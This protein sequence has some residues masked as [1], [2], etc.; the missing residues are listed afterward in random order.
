MKKTNLNDNNLILCEKSVLTFLF[1]SLFFISQAQ[2]GIQAISEKDLKTHLE[3][4]ASDSLEGRSFGT[5]V[6]GLDIA[7]DYLVS[8]LK[9]T[10]IKPGGEN[11]FQPV[12]VVS[13]SP[14]PS[15]NRM[16]IKD[17]EGK[18]VFVTDSVCGNFTGVKSVLLEG[19][20][21]FA[22]FGLVDKNLGYNDFDSLDIRNKIVLF[23]TGTP[24]SY[25]KEMNGKT[26]WYDS[27]L[28][29]AKVNHIMEM[30]AKVAVLIPDPNVCENT[31]LRIKSGMS[32][33]C[34]TLKDG[35]G[36]DHYANFILAAPSVC[37]AITGK[38]GSLKKALLEIAENKK[39]TG[40][41]NMN[42]EIT[43]TYEVKEFKG[44]NVVG[45]VEGSD[46]V[47]K[48]EYVVFMAHY[49]HLGV[50]GDGE[51]YNG[52]D[53][54]GS[55]TVTLMELA[56]AFGSLKVKPER[57]IVFLWVTGEEPGMLGSSWYVAHPLLPLENIIACINLDMVG[58]VFTKKD[59]VWKNSPKMVKNFKGLYALSGNGCPELVAISDSACKKVGLVP[60]K[61][62][63]SNF[64][65]SSDHY[66]F[67]RKGIP[68][69]N[70]STG[71]HADYHKV[72][73]EVSKINFKKMKKVAE[74]CYLVGYDVAN[75]EK[76]LQSI[77][78]ARQ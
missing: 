67:Y 74:V 17:A 2:Q 65:R 7:A 44:K 64:L 26:V 73:D 71:Y 41:K 1:L 50:R 5:K 60:D 51:V 35:S 48:N 22:G 27:R 10:G 77:E 37:D 24:D 66:Q 40:F 62:L 38:A 68:I 59:L 34:Y 23:S 20:V 46:S 8:Y 28:E 13:T 78:I 49:D 75:R 47:L 52:A 21:V 14:E 63:P 33:C 4:I 58:R 53:D 32:G 72:S 36:E 55:G 25:L 9:K 45:F 30:G 3:F 31:Y 61:S 6:P 76:R 12:A 42:A 70:Y 11:Y 54:N 16:V 39:A 15:G 43:L 56:K 18:P 19:E 69:M 29:Q 57:S